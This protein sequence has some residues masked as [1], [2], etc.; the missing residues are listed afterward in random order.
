MDEFGT[1]PITIWNKQIETVEEGFYE[2]KNIRLQKF[3]REKYTSTVTNTVFNK[4]NENLP[5]ISQ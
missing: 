2:I 3:K 4:L 1:I 5:H